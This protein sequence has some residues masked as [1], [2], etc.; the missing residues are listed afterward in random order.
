MMF[1]PAPMPVMPQ[2]QGAPQQNGM[3]MMRP[4]AVV[5]SAMPPMGQ[6]IP[7]QLVQA[8]V[9]QQMPQ[10]MAPRPPMGGQFNPG[11][12]VPPGV[13]SNL[14][15]RGAPQQQVNPVARPVMGGRR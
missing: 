3:P 5:G 14:L 7:Q 8:P 10:Q 6:Q 11:T 4:G 2:G 1:N 9:Q 15:Q 13:L 12:Q